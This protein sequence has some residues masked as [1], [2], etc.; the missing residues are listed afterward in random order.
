M[1]LIKYILILFIA[2]T[3]TNCGSNDSEPTLTLS[4]ANIAGTY[5][6]SNLNTEAVLT[7]EVTPG[8]PVTISTIK[9]KGDT[10]QID[11]VL[12]A[13]GSYSASGQYRIETTVIPVSGSQTVTASIVNFSDSGT[14]N[15]NTT[16]S[17]I[18]F[19]SSK[20]DFLSGTF[21]VVTFNESTFTLTQESEEFNDPI[22]TV[23]NSNFSFIRK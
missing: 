8:V 16:N 13:S 15:V 17:T 12:N 14:F 6:I 5:N 23:L 3:F 10:F 7:T 18:T 11:F 19:T 2:T 9:I 1:K 22:K 20:G 4:T 21:K